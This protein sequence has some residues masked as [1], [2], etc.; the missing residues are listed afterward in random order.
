MI[1]QGELHP[2]FGKVAETLIKLLPSNKPGGASLCVYHNGEKVVDV[3]GGT[4]DKEGSPWEKDTLVFSASTTKGVTSTLLH[5]LVDKGLANY[6]DTVAQ[7]WPEFSQNGKGNITIRHVLSHQAGLYNIADYGYSKEHIWNWPEALRLIEEATPIHEP[8]KHSA[9]HGLT[10]GHIIGGL[11]EKIS[12]KPFQ[13][14]LHEE[15]TAPL[16]LDGMFIGVPDEDLGRLAE[17]MSF[18]GNLGVALKR[19]QKI[20]PI[21]RKYLN[22]LSRLFGADF[23]HFAKALAPDFIDQINFNDHKAMQIIIPS[24][25]GAFTARSLAKMYA[26]LA[27]E[28]SLDGVTVMSK[29]RV[30]QFNTRQATGRDKV[31]NFPMRWRLGYHEIPTRRGGLPNSFGHFGFGGSGAWCDPSKNLAVALTLNTGIG[32]PTGDLRTVRIASDVV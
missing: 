7:H 8:G 24:A 27:N 31:I 16:D 32:T 4:K 21:L 15:I 18:D 26:A 14:V 11:I 10:Y 28:G 5:I 29:E 23:K 3:W 9:Y 19:Y 22:Y 30:A 12:G 13:Q 6:N 25:N 17:L 1:L 20:P 2:D